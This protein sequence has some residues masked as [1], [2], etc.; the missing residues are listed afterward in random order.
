VY[1]LAEYKIPV[2]ITI[3]AF[4]IWLAFGRP[5]TP[6][7]PDGAMAFLASFM[8]LSIPSFFVGKRLVDWLYNPNMVHVAVVLPGH[9][10]VYRMVKV[11]PGIWAEKDVEGASPLPVD[12]GWGDYIVT[13]LEWLD[14]VEELTVRGCDRSQ[15]EP[16][17]A[18]ANAEKV[19]EY[20][21]NYMGVRDAYAKLRA[22]VASIAQDAH[23]DGLLA[24]LD[25]TDKTIAP[26]VS[27]VDLLEEAEDDDPN[28]LPSLEELDSYNMDNGEEAE[29]PEPEPQEAP[30][31]E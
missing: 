4:A 7:P 26:G 23:D 29:G 22:R 21:A 12:E 30:T 25:V 11:P 16:G 8:L 15:M 24:S 13:D 28:D 17:E 9:D 14:D 18:V 6:D 1:L 20:Y 5:E 31:H 27:V 2:S 3:L 10:I 19:E